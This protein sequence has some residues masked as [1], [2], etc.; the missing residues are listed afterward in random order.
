MS[1]ILFGMP[2]N[3]RK[4]YASHFLIGLVF[5]YGIEKLFMQSIGIDAVGVGIAT[6]VFIGMN[7]L[8]DIPSGM[9]AD[10]WSR[11]GVL[12]V[13]TLALALST[14]V[15]GTASSFS[16]Y[17]IG[18]ILY[19]V[20]LVSTSGTYQAITYDSLHE[21]GLSAQYS[22]VM[23]RAFALFLVG[24]GTANLASGFIASNIDYRAAFFISLVPCVLNVLVLLTIKEP[25]FHKAEQKEQF[26]RQIFS[27]SKLMMGN[28]LLRSLAIIMVSL[29]VM[30]L[31][32]DDFGQLY[33]LRYIDKAELL[34]ILWAVFAFAWALGSLIAHRMRAYLH[35]LVVAA[36]VPF[37]GMA[38]TDTWIGLVLFLAHSVPAA[39]LANQ[40]ET[41]VQE[42]TPSS[43]RASILSVLSSFG[44]FVAVP[45]SVGFG[46]L[47]SAHSMM[48]A[49]Y[50]MATL[51]AGVL[52]Y[53]FW[54]S[55]RTDAEEPPR[56]RV[57]P[58]DEP[59][60]L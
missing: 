49:V 9:I 35:W 29:S 21:K 44:R 36:A 39:A 13:A 54:L 33:I 56:G 11:K 8:L 50:V 43:V 6:A 26:L 57:A 20:Y 23:G 55:R 60:L 3:I 27:A 24:A 58:Q 47:I 53:W 16:V 46:W 5:W 22:K 2:A 52:I 31:F 59:T 18:Y 48:W 25:A 15:L 28:L 51:G 1:R 19:S 17:I 37:I 4:I 32:K 10:R 38:L 34:G 14:L 7:L 41:R 42:A 40:I 45:A 30:D 12:L